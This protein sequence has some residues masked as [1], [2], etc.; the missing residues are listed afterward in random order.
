MRTAR[1]TEEYASNSGSS[2]SLPR[3]ALLMLTF[4]VT[5]CGFPTG[6]KSAVL[7]LHAAHGGD[8]LR[9][10]LVVVMRRGSC[11]ITAAAAAAV[12]AAGCC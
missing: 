3:L 11:V 1:S 4:T 6:L 12:V 7:T 8:V 9:L 10:G 2:L 5:I